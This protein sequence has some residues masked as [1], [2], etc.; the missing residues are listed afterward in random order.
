MTALF[1]FAVAIPCAMAWGWPA[2]TGLGAMC[3]VW[4]GPGFG[5][6]AAGARVQL[7]HDK[8]AARAI[9]PARQSI[10]NPSETGRL[11]SPMSMV[12]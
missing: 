4:G 9:A 3:A 1:F 2:G 10:V 6:M 11:S 12:R 7:V 5:V 8:A